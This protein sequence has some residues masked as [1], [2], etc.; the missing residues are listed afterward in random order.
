MSAP[1]AKSDA[2]AVVELDDVT[3]RF[4]G[5]AGDGMQLVGAQFTSASALCGN[6]VR[7]LPDFPAEIRAPAGTLA[8]VSG[9]QVHFGRR[10]V[11]TPGDTL[12]ALV[13]MN[14]AALRANL[15]DLE[16]DGILVVNADA[17]VPDNLHKAGYDK[18]PLTDASLAG[19]RVFAVPMNSLN[20]D[21]LAHLKLSPKEADRCRNFFAL[22]LVSWLYERPLEPTLAWIR[23]K[24]AKNPAVLEANTRTL[25]AGFHYGE[26]THV[27]PVHYRVPAAPIAPGKYRKITGNEAL[28][29]G[30]VAAAE[31]AQLPLVFAGFPMAPASDILQRLAELR[32]F[33]V[34]CVQ[35]EDSAAAISIAL[36]AAFGGALGATATSGPGLCIKSEA[37]GWGVMAE[38]PC[39]II[40][41]QRAGPSTGMPTKTEQADLLQAL[42]GRHGECPLPVL[43]PATPADCFTITY[44]AVRLAIRAMTPVIVLADADLAN[45]AEPWRV[46]DAANLPRFE[47]PRRAAAPS[48][49]GFLPYARDERLVRPWVAAGAPG[50]EHRI[51]GLEK[52]HGTGHVSYEPLNHEAMVRQRA[53]KIAHLANDIPELIVDGPEADDLLVLGWGS[54]LGAIEAA[55]ARARQ[56]GRAVASAHLRY[57][58]PL[59]RNTSNVLAHYKKILVPELNSGQLR[60]V[61]RATLGVET[62]G[63]HKIQGRP[64]LV[65]EIERKIEEMLTL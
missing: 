45:G 3:I 59:P 40:S 41:L 39:V 58:H 65:S 20:R 48:L 19:Y 46:P 38:L 4:A 1:T 30:L 7:T 57:L 6:D 51:G 43:A 61:L 36:G 16:R 14:P 2:A 49:N 53:Q 12:H 64:F 50:L 27:L 32:E 60:H 62:I 44:E 15:S 56:H 47:I 25:K 31:V 22:G 34:R 52:E 35:A 33:D 8:G 23:A 37:I 26:T 42:Y 17:F 10:P 18:N 13:A 5:D 54:T 11:H 21:A 24:F 28:T 63:L 9:F 55:V 29:L